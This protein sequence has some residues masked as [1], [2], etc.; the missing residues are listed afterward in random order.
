MLQADPIPSTTEL[1]AIVEQQPPLPEEPP[2][3]PTM[4]ER[5]RAQKGETD[6]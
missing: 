1:R 6:V 2:Y 5:R 4:R 3:T